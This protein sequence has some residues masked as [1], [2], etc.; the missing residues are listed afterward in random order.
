MVDGS[1][2]L[3]KIYFVYVTFG[4]INEAKKIGKLLV[5]NKLA[6]CVNIF[7]NIFSIYS[8]KN[9]LQEDKECSAFFKTSKTNVPQVI[10]TISKNH[11]YDCPSIS[12]FPIEKMHTEFQKWIVNQTKN[13]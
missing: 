12:A 8:W 5:K 10:K 4:N 7:P 13:I 11:S 6:A 2:I 1:I 3:M 9:K